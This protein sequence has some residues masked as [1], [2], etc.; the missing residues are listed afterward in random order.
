MAGAYLAIACMTSAMTR[1]QVISFILSV[2][3]CLFLILAGWPPVTRLL[4]T[5]EWT[6]LTN[7]AVSLSVMTH[8]EA[9]Q[10]G[11][12][13]FRDLV[14][15]LSHHRL[16]PVH[17]GRRHPQPPGRVTAGIFSSATTMKNLKP[18]ETF[19]Y[20]TI[21]VVVMAVI[22]IA[23]NVIV[24]P[25]VS[26]VDLTEDKLYTLSDGTRHIL[27][28]LDAPVQVRFYFSQGDPTMPVEWKSYAARV[29]DMLSEYQLHAK[30]KLEIKKLDPAPDTEAE[31]SANLDGVEGQT[32]QPLGGDRIYLGLA[33]SC[34]DTRATIPFLSPSREQLLEYDLTRAISQVVRP[35]KVTVGVMSGLPVFGGFNPSMMRM[36]GGRTEPWLFISEL[37][38]DFSVKEVPVTADKI[39]DDIQ[40]LLVIYPK[41]IS[42]SAEYALDQFVL[43]GGKLIAFLDPLSV[44]DTRSADPGNPLQ[45]A[46]DS[47]A[48]LDKLLKAWGL[49]FD[50]GKV[51]MDK[52]FF[53]ELGGED[54]RPRAN[55]S[56]L[57]IPS[58]VM[59]TNDVVTSQ[60][61]RIYLPFAGA[62]SGTPAAGLRQ[63]VLMHSSRNADL[64]EKMLAQFGGSAQDFKPSG[65]EYPLAV[66]LNGRFK[67]AF[68][69]GKPGAVQDDE[70]DKKGENTG[71]KPVDNSLK[72]S[73]EDTVVVLIGDSDLLHEQFYA[74]IQNFF[75]QRVMIP[76]SQNL[77]LVQNLVEQMGGDKD[78]ITI[79]SRATQARPF[80]KVRELQARAE[81]RF[82]SKIKELEKSEQ[83]LE[84]K[85]NELLQGRQPGQQVI[86]SE[87]A[88]KEW[89]QVQ[90]K[91]AEVRDALRQ[92]RRNLRKDI[93]SLQTT[94]QWTNILLMPLAVAVAGVTL[95]LIKRRKTAA[96]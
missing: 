94:L 76:F 58:Q 67:T 12:I 83:E 46:A 56:F 18:F 32:L 65:K 25:V 93:V 90:Q 11:V 80:T 63:T 28:R 78:L 6:W 36:G 91:R 81:E 47:G 82:A 59:D 48:S 1:N 77:T 7:L 20:S 54:G 55:P 79:R 38:S 87:E 27:S 35:Q 49:G 86:L 71:S 13:D 17:H 44:L 95:A 60:I 34:L 41:A 26:R 3:I 92:E 89:Q 21:G 96:R 53:T 33:V 4:D 88:K 37:Q 19:L 16:C 69:E 68:P 10:R 50:V 24:R 29:E 66:R 8:F 2:V 52:E 75:G 42:D 70:K 30:G 72:E 64:T 74:R 43:R 31:D 22:V 39:D 57:Q 51:V 5:L 84:Q 62:F 85:I 40:V 14:F 73:K 23:L 61:G 45:S 9:F 15:F